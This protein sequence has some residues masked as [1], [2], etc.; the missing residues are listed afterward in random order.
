MNFQDLKM[1]R[2]GYRSN[3]G[4]GTADATMLAVNNRGIVPLPADNIKDKNSNQNSARQIITGTVITSCIIQTS[5]LPNR[6]ELSDNDAIFYDDSV[7]GTGQVNGD[8]ASIVF[9][10]SDKNPGDF[11]I[12][13]RHGVNNNLENVF[14]E[15]YS[16]AAGGGQLNYIFIG[17]S[18]VATDQNTFTDYVVFN[19]VNNVRTEIASVFDYDQRPTFETVDYT[20]L[21]PTKLGVLT[22][23]AGEG[24]DGFSALGKL[25][26]VLT[27]SAPTTFAVGDTIT[28]NTTGAK[29]LLIFKVS[30]SIFYA[31]HT[32]QI[33]FDPATDNACT[34]NGAGGGS[35]TGNLSATQFAL[36][37]LMYTTPDLNL[38]F[39]GNMSPDVDNAFDIGS[40]ALRVRDIYVGGTIHGGGSVSGRSHGTASAS[41]P[42]GST[43]QVQLNVNDFANGI[44]WDATNHRFVVITAGVYRVSCVITFTSC[45]AGAGYQASIFGHSAYSVIGGATTGTFVSIGYDD[46]ITFAAGD[47]IELDVFQQT[48]GAATLSTGSGNTFLTVS[49]V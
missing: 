26:E 34:T 32:N 5:A 23:I 45:V 20:K 2:F 16:A 27:F 42:N 14:E 47:P 33:A 49:K 35:G 36:L 40:N 11:I 1:N 15:Y 18:G 43:T 4:G 39:G 28:G 6:V 46:L 29:A 19:A 44:T 24:K 17:R 7:G 25:A 37:T 38:L 48:G 8:T 3:Q 21:D 30:S 22:Y 10:R 12:Q 41:I 13:K 31:D 9:T